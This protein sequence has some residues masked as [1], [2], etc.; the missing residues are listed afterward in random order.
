VRSMC[1]RK[2][3]VPGNCASQQSLLSGDFNKILLQIDKA[4]NEHVFKR[5][6]KEFM[7][8]ARLESD[9]LGRLEE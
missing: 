6:T 4:R 8:S 1:I 9:E 3:R 2:A 7:K 5:A